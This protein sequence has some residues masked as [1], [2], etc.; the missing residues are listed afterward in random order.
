MKTYE[1]VATAYKMQDKMKSRYVEYMKTRWADSEGVKCQVGY[2]Q[3]WAERFLHGI[4]FG[5]SDSTGQAILNK[6]VMEDNNV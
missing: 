4:E 1:E 6:M 3:E 5:C 2:A